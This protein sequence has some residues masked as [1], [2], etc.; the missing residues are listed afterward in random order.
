MYWHT[1]LLTLLVIQLS[2]QAVTRQ[3]AILDRQGEAEA[4]ER[5]IAA[6][7]RSIQE[8]SGSLCKVPNLY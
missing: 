6:M 8:V 7:L 5:E 4:V 1:L 3:R 2:E